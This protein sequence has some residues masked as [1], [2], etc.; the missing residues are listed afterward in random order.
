MISRHMNVTAIAFAALI[1]FIIGGC[2]P[3]E[4]TEDESDPPEEEAADDEEAD[5]EQEESDESYDYGVSAGH[6]DAVDAG[7]EVL[8]EGGSAADAAVAAAYAISVVEPFASGIGGGGVALIQEQGEAPEAYDYREVVPEDGIPASDIGVPGFVAGMTDIHADYGDSDWQ[9]LIDPAIDLAESAEVSDLLAEQI[10][11]S[12]ER[13][14]VE[15]LDQLYPDGAP[16]GPG[17]ELEQAELADTL[18]EIRDDGGEAFYEGDIA[19]ALD[20]EIEGLDM[21]SLANYEVGRHEPATGEFAGYEV[22]GAPPPLPGANVIQALQILEER[23]IAEEERHSTA[24]IHNTAMAWR[25]SQQF[26][27]TDVG[28]PDF[29]DVPVE[30]LTD[31][32]SNAGLAEEIPD[33][34]LLSVDPEQPYGGMDPN[35]THITVV[36]EEGTV[37]SMTNTITN[38][39]GSGEYAE[40]FFLNDQ[41]ARF[42]IGRDGNNEPE[43][44]RRSVTWSSPMIIADEEGPVM[45]IGSPGGERIPIM[46]TQVITDWAGNGADLEGA[47]EAPRFHIEENALIMEEFPATEQQDDLTDI[48]YSE[49]R[50]PP[51]DLYFGSIQALAIDRESSALSGAT[52]DRREGDWSSDTKD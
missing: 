25:L 52:D 5:P 45:G 34:S 18:R 41:M 28:D 10:Q 22:I 50:E 14:P 6:P 16:L 37:V 44:G 36:D 43:P 15:Q 32:E 9:E 2:T 42:D 40:G 20:S 35:T 13:L 1:F 51:T 4:E 47:V 27:E 19:E 38:F 23:G 21:D 7:M 33:D 8:E 46:L 48:G 31:S 39:W 11:S 17:D 30:E 49:L 26:F 3:E 12:E 24:F 29:I